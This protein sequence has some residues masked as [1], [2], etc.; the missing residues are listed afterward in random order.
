MAINISN[1]SALETAPPEINVHLK[2]PEI[3]LYFNLQFCHHLF[4]FFTVTQW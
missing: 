4:I 3:A 2:R 1:V